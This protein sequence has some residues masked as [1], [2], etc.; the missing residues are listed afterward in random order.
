MKKFIIN[1][2]LI[3]IVSFGMLLLDKTG[4]IP[5]DKI[6]AVYDVP[7]VKGMTEEEASFL[8]RTANFSIQSSE[9]VF[10]DSYPKGIVI[11]QEPSAGTKSK[12][13]QIS[14]I[15]SNGRQTVEVPDLKGLTVE[16]AEK[17]LKEAGLVSGI[18]SF[19]SS[20]EEKGKIIATSPSAGIE[21]KA[22]TAVELTVSKGKQYVTVPD[23]RGMSLA[24]AQRAI[25]SKGL[26]LGT[27]KKEVNIEHRFGII[28]RQW[29]LAGK[30]VEKGTSVTVVLNEEE[31]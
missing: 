23:L 15:V 26:L 5:W 10:S 12:T 20:S 19:K 14:I 31:N 30:K 13:R 7:N 1:F 11:A 6:I 22:G 27:V 2:L 25:T 9:K 8:I 17:K 29:P 24:G 18:V 21:T 28:L 16:E 3:I 4:I